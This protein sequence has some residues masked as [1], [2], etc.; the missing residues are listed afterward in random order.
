MLKGEKNKNIM[1]RIKTTSTIYDSKKQIK[2]Q[3]KT[4]EIIQ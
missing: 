2:D 1:Q 4:R 3:K